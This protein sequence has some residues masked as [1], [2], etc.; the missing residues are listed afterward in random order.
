M[1]LRVTDGQ[2]FMVEQKYRLIY[3][4]ENHLPSQDTIFKSTERLSHGYRTRI[5]DLAKKEMKP[6]LI[7]KEL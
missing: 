7:K 3:V 5:K 2:D 6:L 4:S 1:Y